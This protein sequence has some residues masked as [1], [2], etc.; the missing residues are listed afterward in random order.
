MKF[1]DGNWLMRSGVQ[2]MYPAQAYAIETTAETL[3][4]LATRPIRHRGDTLEG[5]ALTVEF[6]SPLP[7]VI[8]VRITHFS[9]AQARGPETPL[10]ATAAPGV[11]VDA[12]EHEATLTSGRLSV[13]IPR[14]ARDQGL[15]SQ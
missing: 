10:H 9:G 5:P 2:V 11:V 15:P 14:D 8:R 4:V 7:D 1:T 12:A 6:A 3:T 13:R